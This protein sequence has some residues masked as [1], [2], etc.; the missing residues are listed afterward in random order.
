M[1]RMNT[2]AALDAPEIGAVNLKVTLGAL[3]ARSAR[4]LTPVLAIVA[5]V[6]AVIAMGV[7][8]RFS[9][10]FCAVTTISS[11]APVAVLSSGGESA[12][13]AASIKHAIAAATHANNLRIAPPIIVVTPAAKS[14]IERPQRSWG[15]AKKGTTVRL[16]WPGLSCCF[17][18]YGAGYPRALWPGSAAPG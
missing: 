17:G 12:N 9:A 13:A 2:V 5:A 14:R 16:A 8:S 15:D 11:R 4:L 18:R 1:P 6:K 7:R 10:R 3:A